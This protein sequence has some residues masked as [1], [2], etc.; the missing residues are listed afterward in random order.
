MAQEL[1]IQM[2]NNSGISLSPR[3]CVSIQST[4]QDTKNGSVAIG[5]LIEEPRLD[6]F[7]WREHLESISHI[8]LKALQ[9]V[10]PDFPPFSVL[11]VLTC[12][13]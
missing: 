4:A 7:H 11:K 9:H 5:C 3:L 10:P 6:L 1:L 2:E 13:L 12:S 8:N